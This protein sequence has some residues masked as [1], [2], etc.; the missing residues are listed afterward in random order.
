VGIDDI[1]RLERIQGQASGVAP[2]AA[3]TGDF[4]ALLDEIRRLSQEPQAA[5]ENADDLARALQQAERDYGV[6][7]QLRALLEEAFRR[8]MS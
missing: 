8:K 1:L 4:R 5:A 6:A 3:G 7:M 2:S